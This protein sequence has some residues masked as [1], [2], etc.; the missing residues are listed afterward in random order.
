M[1]LDPV[2][3]AAYRALLRIDRGDGADAVLDAALGRTPQRDR[4]VLAELVRGTLQWRGRYDHVIGRFSRRRPPTDPRQL[5]VL[6][7]GLHQMLT[8]Q[9]VPP[10]AAVHQAGE[11]ARR[12]LGAGKVG[13]VNGLLQAVRRAVL[14][15]DAAAGSPEA[16]ARLAAHFDDL[17]PGSP[18]WL[19]AWHSHP[20][21]L[22]ERWCDAYGAERAAAVCAWNN[23]PV[24]TVLHVLAPHDPAEAARRLTAAGCPVTAG[25]GP[26]ALTL[27]AALPRA[28]LR[29]V[30]D[31][32]PEVIVQDGTVQEA[33]AWLAAG[34]AV[35]GPAVDLCAAPGGKTVHLAALWP[36]AD[37]VAMDVGRGREALLVDTLARTGARGVAVVRGD[38]LRPPLRPDAWRAALLDGPCSGTG[39]LRR[40]PDGRWRLRPDLPAQ[41]GAQLLE[42]AVRAA[43]LLAPGGRLLYATCSLEAEENGQVVEQLLR[44]CP[45]LQPDPGADDAWRRQW[46]PGETGGDGF[47]AARLVRAHGGAAEGATR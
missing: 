5:M 30:L 23:R 27:A 31:E 39:V 32:A 35:G 17:Q 34:D 19:A 13:F 15:D 1:S 47:Y 4:P 20:R 10:Y 45:Q 44:R 9:G 26:R 18:A 7:L 37:I 24:A 14:G 16:E 29:A 3:R 22:V 38:A 28:A 21:W 42:M 25:P 33:T 8:L 11:L 46:L 41:R 2:R 12:E 43:E 6:R 40:H 36:D